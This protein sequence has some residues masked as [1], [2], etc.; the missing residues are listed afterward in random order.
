MAISVATIR[1]I[2]RCHPTEDRDKV[3]QAILSIFPDAVLEGEDPITGM[4]QSVENFAELLRKQKIRAAARATLARGV[5]GQTVRFSLNKQVAT[6]G[7]ASFS[8][9]QQPLGAID[10][11]IEAEDIESTI[12]DI[13]ADQDKE[14]IL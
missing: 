3:A 9:E 13:L 11:E 6:V 2:A 8:D 10:V 14:E 5:C 4:G 12:A 7:K 1:I